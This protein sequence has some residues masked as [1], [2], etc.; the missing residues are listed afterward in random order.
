MVEVTS[1]TTDASQEFLD[2]KQYKKDGI[3]KYELIFG[4]GFISTGGLV[5]I[6]TLILF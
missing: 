5:F 2:Q 1:T 4:D 3:L 6:E